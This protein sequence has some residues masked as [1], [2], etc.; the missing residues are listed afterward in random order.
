MHRDIKPG[1]VLVTVKDGHPV[2]KLVDFGLAKAV[3]HRLVEHV[4]F[5]EQGQI[6]GTPE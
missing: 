1:N 6:L 5:T 3:G 4:L 2:P